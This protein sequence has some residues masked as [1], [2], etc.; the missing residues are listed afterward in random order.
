MIQ[1]NRR[2]IVVVGG[3]AG[4]A[5]AAARLR[6]RDEFAEIVLL[7]RG[8]DV[9]FANCGLP[10]HI[11]GEIADRNRLSVQ[12]PASLASMLN[13]DVRT[14]TEAI[15]IDREGKTVRI[16]DLNTGAEEEL[17]YDK[18]ILAPG[19]K[20]LRPPLPGIDDRRIHV[21]RNL[22]DM[23]HIK[24]A[25]ATAGRVLVVGGGFIGLEMAEQFVRLGKKISL[26][27]LMPQVLPQMDADMTRLV[28][29]A[30]R[31]NGVDLILGDGIQ[32]FDAGEREIAA[33]LASGRRVAADLVLL[34]I[35]VTPE[36]DLARKAGLDL[37]ERGHVRV[38]PWMTTSDPDIY[39]V[40][41]MAESVDPVFGDAAAVPLGGLANRQ[42]R[43]V[44][45][46]IV[47]G[48]RAG[49]YPGSLGTAIVRA[50]ESTA[51]VTGWTVKRLER[52]GIPHRVA[53]VT[54][55]NHASY[56]PDA[57][58]LSVKI[59]WSPDD[60]RV[61][62][63]QVV[64]VEGVDKRID[65]LATAI[66][67][68]MTV[69]QLAHLELA[70]APPFG[71]SKDPVN[72]AGFAAQNIR[73]GWY[74]PVPDIPEDGE[75]QVV[76]VRPQALFDLCPTEGA[77]NI[78]LGELRRRLGELDAS[79]PVV[80]VCALG[81]TSY[82]ASR[83]LQQHGFDAKGVLGGIRVCRDYST[84]F[85]PPVAPAAPS[86]PNV[87]SIDATGLS[88]PGPILRFEEARRNEPADAVFEIRATDTD[89]FR[90]LARYCDDNGLAIVDM[91]R[92][93]GVQTAR[94]AGADVPDEAFA[95][96]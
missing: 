76:D 65:V 12:T 23:D 83:V 18:L 55:F 91:R 14:R 33:V 86:L 72:V 27:E 94:V 66:L 85:R 9:S 88:C 51:A 69:D 52:A 39:A 53:V 57:I 13:L 6:R 17:D 15:G 8:P 54:D 77:V 38:D 58:P 61:L 80:T 79:R 62:G 22:Q 44:A 36:N 59:T 11:G 87:I 46:H 26:V 92:S 89:F 16:R 90:D 75:S 42:G 93:G 71:S 10:Y 48:D 37:G 28:E 47:D 19:A 81:K 74:D 82:F 95:L 50:F 68:R 43:V 20:P 35:G 64:G 3:V 45:D 63:A 49:P 34:S 73:D 56:Y 70:Y 2:K 31:E 60:G 21:L 84:P 4:G 78:P 32:S 29:D 40:G 1:E 96:I 7:E 5:S 67:G 25:V 24:E 41:D 30:L